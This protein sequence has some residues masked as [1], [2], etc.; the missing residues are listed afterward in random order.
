[1][2]KC[3]Q[4]SIDTKYRICFQKKKKILRIRVTYQESNR[5]STQ[6]ENENNI[7]HAIRERQIGKENGFIFT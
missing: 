6:Q 7:E 3:E 4:I 2:K 5:I 1:M